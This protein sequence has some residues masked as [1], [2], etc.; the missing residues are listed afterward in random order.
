MEL[1]I[2]EQIFW[3]QLQGILKSPENWRWGK[4]SFLGDDDMGAEYGRMSRDSSD[5]AQE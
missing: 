1:G 2:L 5:K 4:D 3:N